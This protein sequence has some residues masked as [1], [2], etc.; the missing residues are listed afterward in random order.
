MNSRLLSPFL[1][2][3]LLSGSA[4]AMPPLGRNATGAVRAVDRAA[5]TL[6]IQ[7]PADPQPRLYRWNE[8]TRFTAGGSVIT[9][10]AIPRGAT[11]AFTYHLPLIG[12]PF[13][14]KVTMLHPLPARPKRAAPPP[15]SHARRP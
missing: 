3:S 1:A 12:G 14:S 5:Q 10:A 2:V 15:S 6:A 8:S 7:S 9:T 4:Q 13:V 11:V